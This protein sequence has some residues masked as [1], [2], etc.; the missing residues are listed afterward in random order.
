MTV[1]ARLNYV[2]KG[3]PDPTTYYVEPPQGVPMCSVVDDPRDVLIS[4]VRDVDGLFAIEEDGFSFVKLPTGFR[5]H[6]DIDA[7]RSRHYPEMKRITAELLGREVAAVFDHAVRRRPKPD[8]TLRGNGATRQPLHRVHCDFT[9]DSAKQQLIRSLGEEA[10]DWLE[11]PFAMVNYWRPIIGPL[12]DDPLAICAPKSVHADD[13]VR[14]RHVHGY[15][16][17]EVYGVA[18]NPDHRWYYMSDMEPDDAIFFKVYDAASAD[19]RVAPHTAFTLPSPP[20][21]MPAR[22]SFELRLMVFYD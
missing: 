21:P 19:V 22:A 6:D 13:L 8:A 7:V 12:R 5:D 14:I 15:G 17:S 1:Q 2:D 3:A 11:R 10:R 20:T 9:P 4:D 18:Y 16:D